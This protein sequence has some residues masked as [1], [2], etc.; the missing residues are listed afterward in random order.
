MTDTKPTPTLRP[1]IAQIALKLLQRV[2]L[3]GQEVPAFVQVV[4]EL[5]KLADTPVELQLVEG[6]EPAKPKKTGTGN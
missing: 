2:Q 6:L 5:Q 3:T 4:N 1:E